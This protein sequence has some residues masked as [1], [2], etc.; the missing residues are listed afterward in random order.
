VRSWTGLGN[1]PCGGREGRRKDGSPVRDPGTVSRGD[2]I[3]GGQDQRCV[4]PHSFHT[5]KVTWHDTNS[6]VMGVWCV[7]G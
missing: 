2:K 6:A 5:S 7:R 1:Q 3:E 4:G